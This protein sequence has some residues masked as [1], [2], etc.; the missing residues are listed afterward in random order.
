LHVRVEVGAEGG[1]PAAIAG[2][3][4]AAI[5]AEIG[6]T[7]EVEV[8]DRGTLERRGYKQLRLVDD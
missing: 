2:L 1:D 4:T 5:E 8:V 3:C 7:A 6:V